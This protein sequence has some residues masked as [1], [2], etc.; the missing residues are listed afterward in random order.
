VT[1]IRPSRAEVRKGN[2]TTP[3]ARCPNCVAPGAG[4]AAR[5]APASTA[6]PGPRSGLLSSVV[7]FAPEALI[8]GTVAGAARRNRHR[9]RKTCGPP[10]NKT[11]A[12]LLPRPNSHLWQHKLKTA[13]TSH[14]GAVHVHHR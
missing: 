3:R 4:G 2:D 11:A 10:Y 7:R 13:L 6:P 1:V 12:A 8:R 9:L 14:T 5:R